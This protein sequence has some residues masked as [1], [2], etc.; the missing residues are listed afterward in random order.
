MA[1]EAR[2]ARGGQGANQG[3]SFLDQRGGRAVAPALLD[4]AQGAGGLSGLLQM[5]DE[6]EC[7]R[8]EVWRKVRGVAQFTVYCA[9]LACLPR[10][11]IMADRGQT[12]ALALT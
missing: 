2:L 3:K 9:R 1:R 7:C 6:C 11:K 12:A 5:V 10:Q 4:K 8:R